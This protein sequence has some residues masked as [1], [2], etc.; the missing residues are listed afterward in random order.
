MVRPPHRQQKKKPPAPVATWATPRRRPS[1]RRKKTLALMKAQRQQL[2]LPFLPSRHRPPRWY[3]HHP[4][5]QQTTTNQ[6]RISPPPAP[7]NPLNPR[8]I[9][10][11]K[12]SA[13]QGWDFRGAAWSLVHFCCE[14]GTTPR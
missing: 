7:N 10:C 11:C 8:S 1:L 4:Q 9:T 14:I 6:P 12:R 13:F 3:P 2:I 5:I